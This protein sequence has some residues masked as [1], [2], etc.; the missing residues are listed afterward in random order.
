[1]ARADNDGVIQTWSTADWSAV[2]VQK[3]ERPY[4]RL[5]ISGVSG[6]TSAQIESLRA[7]G[8]RGGGG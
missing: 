2:G 5:N 3:V 1:L 8:A 6:L 4:E 7:L